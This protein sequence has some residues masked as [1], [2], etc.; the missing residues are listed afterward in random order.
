MFKSSATVTHG[1]CGGANLIVC[2]PPWIPPDDTMKSCMDSAIFDSHHLLQG[3]FGPGPT[4]PQTIQHNDTSSN[5]EESSSSAKAWLIM[6]DL[7]KLLQLRTCNELLDQIHKSNLV[8][9]DIV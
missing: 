9:V 3:F 5:M 7:A 2:N 4:L 1:G 6:S 8:L